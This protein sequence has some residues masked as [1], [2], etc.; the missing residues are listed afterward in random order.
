MTRV[1]DDVSDADDEVKA[2]MVQSAML[3]RSEVRSA[4]AHRRCMSCNSRSATRMRHRSTVCKHVIRNDV[5]PYESI[6]IEEMEAAHLRAGCELCLCVAPLDSRSSRH[7]VMTSAMTSYWRA[8]PVRRR[9]S[10]S[11]ELVVAPGDKDFPNVMIRIKDKN[12][13]TGY[14][15]FS[16]K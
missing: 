6:Q 15:N 12:G 2:S 10:R 1:A 4:G 3:S 5:T 16:G 8:L 14:I 13:Q 7:H 11:C 9:D